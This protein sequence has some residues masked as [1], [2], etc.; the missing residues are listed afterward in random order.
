MNRYQEGT[1]MTARQ[2]A[3]APS[4]AKVRRTVR[5]RSLPAA[6]KYRE[7][8]PSHMSSYRQG[9][10]TVA[11]GHRVSQPFEVLEPCAGKL[12]CTVPRGRGT[13]NRL[14]LPGVP[15][16]LRGPVNPVTL[17]GLSSSGSRLCR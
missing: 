6:G 14:L 4:A 12:A 8:D 16:A 1:Q 15:S 2:L 10:M 17:C 9:L 3:G 7:G 5:P 11:A 13:G